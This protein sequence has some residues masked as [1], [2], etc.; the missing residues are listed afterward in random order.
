[1]RVSRSGLVVAAVYAVLAVASTVYG[2]SLPDP[3]ESSVLMGLPLLPALL[4]VHAFGLDGWLADAPW[5]VTCALLVPAVAAGLYAA[6]WLFG[7]LGFRTR[8][9]VGAGALALLSILLFWPT[10]S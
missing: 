8:L 3:K 5:F 1:M 4:V 10:R 7:A 2:R 9:V 6:C